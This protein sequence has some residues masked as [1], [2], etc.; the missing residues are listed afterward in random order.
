MKINITIAVINNDICGVLNFGC[1]CAKTFGSS[2]CSAMA[3][4][5]RA[6]VKNPLFRFPNID[7]NAPI[8]INDAPQNPKKLA[9]ESA[10][11]RSEFARSGSVPTV[12]NRYQKSLKR[13]RSGSAVNGAIGTCF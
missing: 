13:Q 5:M 3:N 7:I 1:V 12:D 11:G 8:V 6:D 9:A 2:F 10:S 4:G